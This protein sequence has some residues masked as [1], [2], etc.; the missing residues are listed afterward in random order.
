M[1]E[2]LTINNIGI[3]YKYHAA[4]IDSGGALINVSGTA[5]DIAH[6]INGEITTAE[7]SK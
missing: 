2:R 5:L 3:K 4:K 1:R 7:F 6:G